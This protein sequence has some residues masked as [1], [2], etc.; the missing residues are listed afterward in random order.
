MSYKP[1]TLVRLIEDIQHNRL[2]LPHIQRPFVW[3]REQMRRLFDSLMRNYPIQTLLFWRTKSHIKAR[4][5]LSTVEWNPDL[6]DH[7]E[8]EL[9]KANIEKV[10]VLDGQQR[11]QTLFALFAGSVRSEKNDGEEE[12]WFDLSSG[13][14]VDTQGIRYPLRFSATPLEFPWYRLRNLREKDAQKTV[15]QIGPPINTELDKRLQETPEQRSARQNQV[16][17]NL[18]MLSSLLLE[19]K[20]FWIEELDGVNNDLPY[21][22]ILEIFIRVNSG[23]TKLSSSDLM[24]AAMKEGWEAVEE[25]I[26]DVVHLLNEGKLEFDKTFA[27]KCLVVAQGKS[28]ELGPDKFGPEQEERLLVE[29]ISKSWP[30]AER[31]FEQLRDFIRHDLALYSDK[32]IRSYSCFVPLFDYLFHNPAPGEHDRQLMRAYYYKSQL[33]NWYSAQTDGLINVLHGFVGKK[34]TGF[35]LDEIKAYFTSRGHAVE[36]APAH[37]EDMRL[38]YI[39]LNLIYVARFGTSP[40]DVEY[41]GNEPQIDHI[42]PQSSLRSKLGLSTSEINHLGNY[43]FIGA[44]ENLRKRAEPPASYFGRLKDSGV[45]ISR[46]LLLVDV[47]EDPSK[48]A[49]DRTAYVDFRNRRLAEIFKVGAEVVNAELLR[50]AGQ[51]IPQTA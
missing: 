20:Y 28:A 36:L 1:K 35:P 50:A 31:T 39:M 12:A 30:Q 44:K 2:L 29:Q 45:D 33:F 46:H 23:G 43:R 51:S 15:W 11:L 25:N 42:Y 17:Q 49:F 34:L 8:R 40:F 37:L 14:Q 27:L 26:E 24:F 13:T 48:L 4:R 6:S 16:M 18:S 7:Y 32:V 41:Q 38:R 47:A 5:F 19:E 21:E 10:F 22:R 3:D 9:S